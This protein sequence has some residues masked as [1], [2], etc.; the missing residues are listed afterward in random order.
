MTRRLSL[1]CKLYSPA[2]RGI[3]DISAQANVLPIIVNGAR[4]FVSGTS[5]STPVCVLPP[6]SYLGRP[7]ITL[8]VGVQQI[9]AGIISLLNNNRISDGKPP[10][11][12][13][14]IWLYGNARRGLMDITG[15]SNPGCKTDGFDAIEEWDPVGPLFVHHF[16]RWLTLRLL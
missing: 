4:K 1:L 2:G 12:F 5:G 11:G 15:G 7:S 16:R 13:L 8:T 9:V 3:P 14:N 10:L 6:P